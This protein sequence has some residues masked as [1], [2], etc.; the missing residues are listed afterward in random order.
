MD[1]I[2]LG[3]LW[4]DGG[5]VWRAVAEGVTA[6]GH[7]PVPLT[8]PG[9]GDG[10]RSATLADQVAVVVGA[11]DESRGPALVIG[12][13]GS[14]TLAWLAADARHAA[15]A[16]VGLIGGMPTTE[17]EPY[18]SGLPAVDGALPFPGWAPFEGPDSDDLDQAAR[19]AFEADAIPVP[20]GVIEAP[21]HYAD[22]RRREVPVT[23]ICPEYSPEEA[24]QWVASGEIPELAG[25]TDLDYVDID[26]GHWPMISAPEALATILADLAD[27]HT[28]AG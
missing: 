19:A 11:L 5:A 8:L 12:H 13:S 23:M 24:R 2:L 27:R 20:A 21:V 10:N 4:L 7:R 15:V 18:F 25:V 28:A 26:S 1:V 9:Q 3:G 17:G 16:G 14:C 22:E 6:R